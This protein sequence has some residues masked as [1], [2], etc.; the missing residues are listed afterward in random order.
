LI[1]EI[2]RGDLNEWK[3]EMIRMKEE[4]RKE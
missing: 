4:L 1:K 3:E 2:M